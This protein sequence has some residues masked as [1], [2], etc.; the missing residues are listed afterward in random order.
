MEIVDCELHTIAGVAQLQQDG[1]GRCVGNAS[2]LVSLPSHDLTRCAEGVLRTACGP[3]SL[4]V[5]NARTNTGSNTRELKE[6][7]VVFVVAGWSCQVVHERSAARRGR[8]ER[9]YTYGLPVNLTFAHQLNWYVERMCQHAHLER[10]I[11]DSM[12]VS[13]YLWIGP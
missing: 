13:P 10:K 9:G 6:V 3:T 4:T 8:V 7:M 11:N 12:E 5:L 1:Y 2:V